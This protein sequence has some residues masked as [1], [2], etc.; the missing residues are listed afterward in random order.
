VKATGGTIGILAAREKDAHFWLRR[1]WKNSDKA[2][3]RKIT[4]FST[5]RVCLRLGRRIINYF[6]SPAVLSSPGFNAKESLV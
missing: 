4:W 6:Y 2:P 5:P 3:K 1:T